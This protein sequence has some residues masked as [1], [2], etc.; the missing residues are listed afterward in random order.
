[1]RIL[2]LLILALLPRVAEPAPL[3]CVPH[4]FGTT[5]A[6]PYFERTDDGRF[7]H[8][9]C[10]DNGALQA[11]YLACTHGTCLPVGTFFETLDGLVRSSDPIAALRSAWEK[12]TDVCKAPTGNM[13]KVCAAMRASQAAHRPVWPAPAASAPEPAASA[14]Q[15]PASAPPPTP[16][17]THQVKTN[18][19]TATRP[20]YTL[21]DGVRG[22]KEVARATVG[23]PCDTTR[24]TLASGADLWAEFGP[25]FV[26]GRVALCSRK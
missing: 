3:A 7:I 11:V 25:D 16:V 4:V 17:Y 8:L 6:G 15:P 2:L 18:G 22:T 24:P 10:D 14:P 21:A 9:W 1:M 5:V 20:A 26:Q 12:N 13:A 19:T 23:Q